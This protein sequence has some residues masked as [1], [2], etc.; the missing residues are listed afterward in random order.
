[1]PGDQ[2]RDC[3][4]RSR[5]VSPCRARASRFAFLDEAQ[6][7]DCLVAPEICLSISI[8]GETLGQTYYPS[9]PIASTCLVMAGVLR[10]SRPRLTSSPFLQKGD[11]PLLMASLSGHGN[12]IVTV[13]NYQAGME[14]TAV[15]HVWSDGLGKREPQL[16]IANTNSPLL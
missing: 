13:S 12:V 3:Y 11:C 5:A 7:P 9:T 2:R 10:S 14:Y 1:M 6:R 8:L 16:A 15:S 4:I